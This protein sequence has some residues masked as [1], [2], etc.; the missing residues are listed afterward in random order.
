MLVILSPDS[1]G[2]TNVMDEVSFALEE[3]KAVIPVLHRDC[4]IPF[5][6]RRVHRVDVRTNYDQGL[7]DLLGVLKASHAPAAEEAEDAAHLSTPA[8]ADSRQSKPEPPPK[9]ANS[10]VSPPDLPLQRAGIAMPEKRRAL[11]IFNSEYQYPGFRGLLSPARDAEELARVLADPSI[12]AFEVDTLPNRDA[13]AVNEA[14]EDFFE[15]SGPGPDDLLLLYFSGHGVTDADGHLYLAVANSAFAGRSLRKATAVAAGFIDKTMRNSRSRRQILILDCCHSGAFAEGMLVKAG[16]LPPVEA[17][18]KAAQGKGRIVLTASTGT[19]FALEGSGGAGEQPSVYTR[20]LVRGLETGEAD[21]DGDGQVGID[22]LHDYL[23]EQ[24][25]LTA[26]HQTPTMTGHLEG[27]LFIARSSV[28]RPAELPQELLA[29]LDPSA[30]LYTRLGAVTELGRFLRG[31]HPGRVLAARRKL[32]SIRDEDDS[33]RVVD[34]AARELFAET[35]D[36]VR[37]TVAGTATGARLGNAPSLVSVNK[38][39]LA[40]DTRIHPKDGLTYVWIPPGN[41]MMGC[42]PGDPEAFDNESSAHP[43]QIAEGFWLCRTQVT[44]AA[45]KKVMG[46]GN[47]SHFKGDQLPVE[48]VSWN[49]AVAYCKAIG[50][51]LPTEKEWEYAA[52]A[53]TTE[54]RYGPID[55]IAWYGGSSGK[56]KGTTHPVGELD[57]NAFGLY[58]MLGN[59]WEWTADNYDE[60]TKV[61]R[62]GSWGD[63]TGSVRASVRAGVGPSDR[64]IYVGFR[65]VGELR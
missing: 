36:P 12:G 58:D 8:A 29:A 5:R 27:Q 24:V 47:P 56:S 62:G 22:E 60:K 35:S 53:G 39:P 7:Q 17:S 9:P 44:Q 10:R 20:F 54:S 45:W 18:F 19:Q 25:P 59:V 43:E 65:C 52:R 41:F 63:I 55:R 49:D 28:V 1:V 16:Q 15:H 51:R 57:A 40:G 61:L 21:R 38:P 42:L 32:T 48:S 14:I 46:G 37:A 2:S 26:P 6:L 11:I 64:S 3:Q 31:D 34:S 23:S 30:Q 13:A 50:G 4:D 33:R